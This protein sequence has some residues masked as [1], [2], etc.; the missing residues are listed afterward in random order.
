MSSFV[1]ILLLGFC[2]VIKGAPLDKVRTNNNFFVDI[3]N[4]SLPALTHDGKHEY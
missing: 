4:V 1:V 2:A 3:V